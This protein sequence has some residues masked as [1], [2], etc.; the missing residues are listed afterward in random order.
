MF[1]PDFSPYVFG[2][3]PAPWSASG[4]P[5]VRPI[6]LYS[7]LWDRVRQ[8]PEQAFG[9]PEV[10]IGWLDAAHVYAQHDA[11][12]MKCPEKFCMTLEQLCI[13]SRYHQWRNLPICQL[14][15]EQVHSI[16]LPAE[17][18]VEGDGIV[19]AAPNLVHHHVIAHNYRPPDEFVSAV[20]RSGGINAESIPGTSR[21]ISPDLLVYRNVDFGVLK[22]EVEALLSK[23]PIAGTQELS[24]N[25]QQGS[26][27]VEFVFIPN[28]ATSKFVQ[29]W[30]L[31]YD[32]ILNHEQGAYGVW[33][34]L[35]DTQN[36]ILESI[37]RPG[38]VPIFGPL[39]NS[40]RIPL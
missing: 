12:V 30:H 31:P 13:S 35:Q 18:R 15:R 7:W 22:K 33:T 39:L 34:M 11:A 28:E 8:S 23:G 9:K 19:F 4:P 16:A 40:R 21:K 25:A 20:C 37:S 1:F 17:I 2:L 14:C 38:K 6:E 5:D 32:S 26:L 36:R 3:G 10:N 27:W 29:E 24:F